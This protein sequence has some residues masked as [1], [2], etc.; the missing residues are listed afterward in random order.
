LLFTFKALFIIRDVI[1]KR[2]R[3]SVK[4]ALPMKKCLLHEC[5]RHYPARLT[6]TT[7]RFSSSRR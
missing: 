3:N 2:C 6:G 4:C 1:S 7:L 5:C